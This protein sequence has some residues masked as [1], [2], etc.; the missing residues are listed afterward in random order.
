MRA[1]ECFI[2]TLK[3]TPAEA[4]LISHRLMLR[5]GMIRQLASGLYSWLPLGV[6]VLRRIERIVHEEMRAIGAQEIFM[7]MVQP[8][9][10]WQQS[11]R[12]EDYGHELLRFTDRHQRAFCLAPTHEE[13]ITHLL[14]SELSSYRQLPL[15]L[16]QIQTKFRDEIRPRFGVMRGREFV[17]KDAYSFHLDDASLAQTY[18]DMY[19][20]Y[21]NIFNRIGLEYRAVTAD[22]GRIGGNSSHEFHVLADAGEDAIAFSD[23]SDYAANIELTKVVENA[24]RAM[25]QQALERFDTPGATTIQDLAQQY[26]AAPECSVK[27]LL[28]HATKH[29]AEKPALIALILRG[30]HRLNTVKAE[31]HAQIKTPLQ[32]ASVAEIIKLVGVKPGSIGPVELNIPMLV[33]QS[34]AVLSDFTCGANREGQHY[35]GVNW[36]RDCPTP[37]VADLRNAVDGD[38]SP[39]GVGRLSIRRG[40]EVGHIFQLGRKYAQAMNLQ[41]TN[42]QGKQAVLTMGC[43]GIGISRIVAACIEQNHDTRGIIWPRNIAPFALAIVPINYDQSAAVRACT[44]DLCG[45]LE[46]AGIAVL[47][48]DRALR[49]GNKLADIELIGIPFRM[50]I[51]EKGLVQGTVEWQER[52]SGDCENLAVHELFAQVQRRLDGDSELS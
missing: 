38:L 28:V 18:R 23:S 47:V 33:D 5:S 34:A 10:L 3:E 49:L 11:G 25:P 52:R 1:T 32:M 16:Y 21:G 35:R 9:E 45:Q 40:I 26:G 39:D 44:D 2:P 27:T 42:Q 19:H 13:V 24:T 7:P 43:Y 22:T 30:D 15:T 14:Q 20:A 31:S 41:L 48:D 51:G 17:M 6:R 50:I 4:E 12:W 46:T 36:E 29:T 8:A 37:P